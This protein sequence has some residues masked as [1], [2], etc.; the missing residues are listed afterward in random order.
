MSNVLRFNLI[1]KLPPQGQAE[2]L[3]YKDWGRLIILIQETAREVLLLD[4]EWNL[5][6]LCEWFIENRE[7]LRCD[8]LWLE[9]KEQPFPSES[10]SQCLER[11]QDRDFTEDEEDIEEEWFNA[12]F[13]FRQHHALRLGLRGARIPDI[14][15]GLNHGEG[16]ISLS[17]E[18]DEWCYS[19]SMNNFLADFSEKVENFLSLVRSPTSLH[20]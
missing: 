19:F 8:T 13:K 17:T 2:I 16:E 11:L 6:S 15:I 5:S 18:N 4:T 1:P 12:I 9:G 10:L 20:S 3:G 7:R 14:I